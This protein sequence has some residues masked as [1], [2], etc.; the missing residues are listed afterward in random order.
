MYRLVIS[1][2]EEKQ[3]ELMEENSDLRT[4][5]ADMQKELH[6]LLRMRTGRTRVSSSLSPRSTMTDLACLSPYSSYFHLYVGSMFD[7]IRLVR[8]LLPPPTVPSLSPI[9]LSNHLLL[10]LPLFLHHCTSTY[11]DDIRS[12][13][14]TSLSILSTVFRHQN[15]MYRTSDLLR[16]HNNSVNCLKDLGQHYGVL[17]TFAFIL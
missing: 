1:N 11:R 14:I 13:F 9:A 7:D 2:Y 17:C 4:C 16:D 5:L 6:A 10:H 15:N 8:T 12:H 3:K